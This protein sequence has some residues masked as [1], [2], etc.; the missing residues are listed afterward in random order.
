MFRI[1]RSVPDPR[2]GRIILIRIHLSETSSDRSSKLNAHQISLGSS[3]GLFLR[4]ERSS[5]LCPNSPRTRSSELSAHQTTARRSSGTFYSNCLHF[6]HRS[7]VMSPLQDFFTT[8]SAFLGRTSRSVSFGAVCTLLA[9]SSRVPPQPGST[10]GQCLSLRVPLYEGNLVDSA[11]TCRTPPWGSFPSSSQGPVRF[12]V[13][14]PYWASLV[15]SRGSCV[16]QQVY[17]CARF[18]GVICYPYGV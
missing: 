1:L 16:P 18:P 11:V 6:Y 5:N 13:R 12:F 14:F 8:T 2:T 7:F 3:L 4:A 15:D 17:L 10:S 9:W